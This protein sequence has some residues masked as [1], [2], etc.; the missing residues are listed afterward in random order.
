VNLQIKGKHVELSPDLREY[1]ERK[2]EK[3][4]RHLNDDQLRVELELEEE[5]NPAI[6]N[7]Q[8]AEAT[9]WS[10]GSVLRAHENSADMKA[11]IDLLVAKLERQ[12]K[13]VHDRRLRKPQHANAKNGADPGP[14]APEPE[15]VESLIVKTKQFALKP[16]SAEEAI[17]Q[18]ELLGHAFFVFRNAETLEVNVLYK[19]RDGKYG[20]IEP[21]LL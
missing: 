3:I 8:R 17:L 4:E 10:N 18:L 19:R 2:L 1:A 9:V 13:R 5:Q 16:M 20:L 15:E 11:S 21:Q 12:A 7:T 14:H 6:G